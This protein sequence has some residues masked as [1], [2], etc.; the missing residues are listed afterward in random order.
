MPSNNLDEKLPRYVKTDKVGWLRDTET[1]AI[2]SVDYRGQ[3]D[4]HDRLLKFKETQD[5][6]KSINTLQEEVNQLKDI[7]QKLIDSKE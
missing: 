3:K 6:I 1:G 7:I 4:Y 2:L 5:K